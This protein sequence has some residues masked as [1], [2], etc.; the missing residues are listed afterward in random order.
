MAQVRSCWYC[1]SFVSLI[2]S[3]DIA[4]GHLNGVDKQRVRRT[5]I[6][7]QNVVRGVK[8]QN[9]T[10]RADLVYHHSLPIDKVE[11]SKKEKQSGATV[12]FWGSNLGGKEG[13]EEFD[14]QLK[15]ANCHINLCAVLTVQSLA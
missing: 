5:V 11:E 7:D 15:L 6:G 4:A 12:N 8:P 3:S 13:P 10:E 2:P 9:T 14:R 1:V